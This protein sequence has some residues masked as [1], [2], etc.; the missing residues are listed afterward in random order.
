MTEF[1]YSLAEGATG[2]F[3]D[4]DVTLGN[5]GA[6]NATVTTTSADGVTTR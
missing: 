4:L 1:T 6:T 5:P 2:G 3:F